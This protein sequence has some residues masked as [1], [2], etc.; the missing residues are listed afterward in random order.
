VP[1]W[2][3]HTCADAVRPRIDPFGS[4]A[5]LPA[6]PSASRGDHF[7]CVGWVRHHRRDCCSPIAAAAATTADA[8]SRTPPGGLLRCDGRL[9]VASW[10]RRPFL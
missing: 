2:P 3:P 10:V 7:H 4:G 8:A 1:T 5:T 9:C 6:A